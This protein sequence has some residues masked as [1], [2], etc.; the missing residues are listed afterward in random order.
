MCDSEYDPGTSSISVTWE[1]VNVVPAESK[2]LGVGSNHLHLRSP[3]TCSSLRAIGL[4]G[5]LKY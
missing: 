4:G 3:D 2:A 5:Q 1:L